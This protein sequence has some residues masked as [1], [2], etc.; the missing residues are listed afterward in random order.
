[1]GIQIA[2]F[3]SVKESWPETA[4]CAQDRIRLAAG[5]P[6]KRAVPKRTLPARV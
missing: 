4:V 5:Y 2:H 1:M 3:P 6:I